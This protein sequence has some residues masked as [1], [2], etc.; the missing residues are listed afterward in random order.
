MT[1]PLI[2]LAGVYHSDL[3]YDR[4]ADKTSKRVVQ[5]YEIE[6]FTENYKYITLDE[7]KISLK[8]NTVIIAKPGQFRTSALHFSCHFVHARVSDAVL[9]QALDSLPNAFV[10]C[11]EAP[12]IELI[13]QIMSLL[14]SD[15]TAATVEI[16]GLFL[17]LVSKLMREYRTSLNGEEEQSEV[18]KSAVMSAQTFMNINYHE[19]ITLADIAESVHLS[20][21]YFHKLF[22]ETCHITPRNYL[23]N[24]RLSKAANLLQ[25]TDYSVTSIS[26]RCGFSSYNYFCA[27]FKS[28]YAM[29]PLEYRKSK[30]RSYQTD[31]LN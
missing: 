24:V 20:P 5:K 26:E 31:E 6:L 29:T 7:E 13:S 17:L 15:D 9:R 30:C 11:D 25:T 21:N 28:R 16:T 3:Y 2:T 27:V 14:Q 1:Y 23:K 10:V 22:T 12:Y 18:K 8:K 4:D 19:F